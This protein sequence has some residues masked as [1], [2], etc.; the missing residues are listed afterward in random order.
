MNSRARLTA[1]EKFTFY[2]SLA[3]LLKAVVGHKT[4]IDLRNESFVYGTIED[5]DACMNVV[6]NNCIFTDPRGDKFRFD[7]FFVQARNIRCVHIPPNNTYC[8]NNQEIMSVFKLNDYDC[9][10][11]DL[12]NTLLWYNV[13]EM[14]KMEYNTLANY[15][16]DYKGYDPEYLC[17]PLEER[18]IDFMQ[19]GLC[20]DFDRGN[21]LKL[22]CDGDVKQ[23]SHGMKLMTMEEIEQIYPNRHWD[24][25][26]N[27]INDPVSAWNSPVSLKMRTLLDYFD[28]PASLLFARAVDAADSKRKEPIKKYEI[29]PDI[30]AGLCDMFDRTHFEKGIGQY[31]LNLKAK[32]DKYIRQ[33]CPKIISWLREIKKNKLTFLITGSNVD[34]A[35]FTAKHAIGDDWRS[36]FDIIICFARKP[37]FFTENRPFIG[38]SGYK[39]NS[40]IAGKDLIR[41]EI[42]SQGNWPELK[43]FFKDITKKNSPRCLYFG[44]N[45]IQDIYTPAAHIGWDTVVVSEE[46]HAEEILD[47]LS[48]HPDTKTMRSQYWGSYFS[49]NKSSYPVGT[50]WSHMIEK[51]S[52]ICIPSL[53]IPIIPAIRNELN[54]LM[55]PQRPIKSQKPTFKSKRA[56]KKQEEDK[57]AMEKLLSMKNV[58]KP[59][60]SYNKQCKFV[61]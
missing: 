48:S 61:L 29:W 2:N 1:R 50:I 55:G 6:M 15:L 26:D 44:D 36:L 3:I 52:K 14:V 28:M 54:L 56:Q 42:Y 23:A 31:F 35:D 58:E 38:L 59:S 51:Y 60:C 12:D 20:V 21:I 22:G 33:C 4:T 7:T 57:A 41:G 27:F 25:A 32:P 40:R 11:F 45:I 8:R 49:D 16:V 39:E 13:T 10:G 47:E 46:M 17:K 34:F 18:D 5:A 9:I 37:G 43:E 19:K 24:I 53:K 30:Y